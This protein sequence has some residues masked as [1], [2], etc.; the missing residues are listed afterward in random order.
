MAVEKELIHG[1]NAM[2]NG[3]EEGFNVLY[4]YTYNYVYGRAKLIMKNE[5]DA[6]DLTQE[7]FIQAYKNIH[8]LENAHNIYAWLGSIVYRQGMRI[9]RKRKNELLVEEEAESIFT[10]VIS[11]DKDFHPE[12]STELE[13]TAKIIKDMIDELPELQ[14]VAIMAF[15][16]DNMKIDEIAEVFECSSNTIKSR[17]NYAKKALKE[18]V[19]A[20]EKA[21]RYKLHSL[22]PAVLLAACKSLF[23]EKEYMLAA[24]GAKIAYRG[25]CDSVGFVT[26]TAS[27]TSAAATEA[28]ATAGTTTASTAT[29][30]ATTATATS[31]STVATGA[32]SVAV[33]TGLSL[34]AKLLIGVAAT[35]TVG[36]GG[37]GV[38][39]ATGNLDI[40][41]FFQQEVVIDDEEDENDD[42]DEVVW[43]ET[44]IQEETE[45]QEETETQA[46]SEV[47]FAS[48]A[49]IVEFMLST[50]YKVAS[51]PYSEEAISLVRKL[52]S[53]MMLDKG[54]AFDMTEI[55]EAQRQ[56]FNYTLLNEGFGYGFIPQ[57]TEE[58]EGNP[59]GTLFETEV[60]N[61]Y[62]SAFYEGGNIGTPDGNS[63]IQYESYIVYRGSD[64]GDWHTFKDYTMYQYE[65]YLLIHA[66][67]YY[68][69]SER[70]YDAELYKVSVLFKITENELYPVQMLHVNT[71]FEEVAIDESQL[72]ENTSQEIVDFTAPIY[73]GEDCC[74][75]E[76]SNQQKYENYMTFDLVIFIPWYGE[77]ETGWIDC[78]ELY[79][80]DVVLQGNTAKFEC[81][82]EVYF[83][84]MVEYY[85]DGERTE[86]NNG[87]Y[88]EITIYDDGKTLVLTYGVNNN[89]DE[90]MLNTATE[91]ITFGANG[92]A[93]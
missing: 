11:E 91:P 32:A 73:W 93:Y 31:A 59:G 65:D 62:L 40:P 77:S 36:L 34:G 86:R 56:K 21:N 88:G 18:K 80:Y 55:T 83:A 45:R 90:W 43:N 75:I 1:I 26:N 27:V 48:Y 23:T 29:G 60:L 20:H 64:A 89:T 4:S 67:C 66:P 49:D 2:M 15:Y 68:M 5:E 35:L 19:E 10:D 9:Y 33:K 51:A 17:L 57:V 53:T 92:H 61:A 3:K 79:C 7:T 72:D 50:K 24:E 16:Y 8:T 6:L 30:T 44:E 58:V 12:E 70:V 63:L 46:E 76:V 87:F 25:V 78:K 41:S 85:N 14:R 71:Q 42:E 74:I 69:D 52:T 81:D 38:A 82:K 84:D 37:V 47:T 54:Q 28:S 22:T 13:A 39:T